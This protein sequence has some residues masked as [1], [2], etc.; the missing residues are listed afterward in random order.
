VIVS[1]HP[2]AED[3]LVD[4]AVY[5]AR[6]GSARLGQDFIGEFER[7]IDLLRLQPML[8]PVWRGPFRRLPIRRFPYSVVYHVSGD[9]LRIVALAHQRRRPGYWRSR[10]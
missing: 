10:T 5:Y 8:G 7:S 4:A 1:T 6:Q 3:E 2:L 9:M